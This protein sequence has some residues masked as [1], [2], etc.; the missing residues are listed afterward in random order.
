MDERVLLRPDG[1]GMMD[2][3]EIDKRLTTVHKPQLLIISDVNNRNSKAAL[4]ILSSSSCELI[5]TFCF[6]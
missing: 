2:R 5:Q 4:R 6:F 3:D 1:A